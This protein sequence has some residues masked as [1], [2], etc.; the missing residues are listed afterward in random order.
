MHNNDNTSKFQLMVSPVSFTFLELLAR[1]HLLQIASMF[2]NR[3]ATFCS[4]STR[5][6]LHLVALNNG[7]GYELRRRPHIT[8]IPT[9]HFDD[10]FCNT[11]NVQMIYNS[12]SF[13]SMP[14]YDT[15]STSFASNKSFKKVIRPFLLACHPD[16]SSQVDNDDGSSKSRRKQHPL[17]QQAKETNLKAV[18]TLNGLIDVLDDLI[19]RCTPPSY[20]QKHRGAAEKKSAASLPELNSRYEIEFIL[21]PTTTTNTADDNDNKPIK[22][23]RRDKLALTLRSITISFP[24][25][26]RSNVRQYALNTY[27]EE[28]AYQ[29]AQQLKDHAMSELL[30]L[31]TIAG[32]SVPVDVINEQRGQQGTKRG[33]QR[34]QKGQW[35]LSDHFLHELGIDPSTE[36]VQETPSQAFFGRTQSRPTSPHLRQTQSTAAPPTYSHPQLQQQREAFMQSFQKVSHK[37]ENDYDQAFLDAQADHTTSRLNLYN[38]NTVEGRERR[39]QLVSSICGGVRIWRAKID[40]KDG[41]DKEIMEDEVPEGLD[42]VAQLI[43]IRRLSLILYDNFDYL[44]MEKMGRMYEQLTIVLTPPRNNLT[45]RHNRKPKQKMLREDGTRIHPGRKL[46]KWERNRKKRDR[47]QNLGSR[48]KMRYIAEKYLG[49]KNEDDEEG[50]QEEKKPSY[51]FESGFRFSY[52]TQ[53]DQGIGKVTAYIPV[54]FRDGELVRQMYTHLYDYFDNCCGKVGW[55]SYGADGNIKANMEDDDTYTSGMR[56]ESSNKG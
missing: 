17:S 15:S 26:L 16:V 18:Q 41:S 47:L 43:A 11:N 36:D 20:Q 38:E 22:R 34:K 51:Q 55:L 19:S 35:T 48:G 28:E 1:W 14:S 50:D 31:L 32:M 21:P 24:E 39:E 12:S 13:S 56:Q 5:R 8:R 29:T 6:G 7:R 33:D 30:R 10:V 4:S 2:I 54:D 40:D 37:F 45:N 3:T 49:E 25:S 23:K 9:Q 52:G 27:P 42:V 53:S 44:K 46:N